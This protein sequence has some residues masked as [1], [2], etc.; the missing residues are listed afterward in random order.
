ML[1]PGDIVKSRPV[2]NSLPAGAAMEKIR[3]HELPPEDREKLLAQIAE[4]LESRSEILF[5]YAH[6]SFVSNGPFRDLDVAV[7]LDP[8]RLPTSRFP[9]EDGLSLEV[10]HRLSLP[11][12]V[13][14]RVLNHAPIV[15]QY[16]VFRGRLL[17]DRD[18]AARLERLTYAVVRYL[19][20]KPILDHHTREAF[21]HGH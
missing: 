4:V 5:A 3:I 7:Y 19:D 8:D 1:I 6:G 20:L 11:F 13:D 12:P 9:Y 2:F 15:F 16:G 17:L 21:G 18:P 10:E 14:V